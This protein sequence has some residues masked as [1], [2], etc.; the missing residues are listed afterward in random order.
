MEL[1]GETGIHRVF[2]H[3]APPVPVFLAWYQNL[4]SLYHNTLDLLAWTETSDGDC[5]SVYTDVMTAICLGYTATEHKWH[6]DVH[7]GFR[8]F[9]PA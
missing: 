7:E 8:T 4:Y 3:K 2:Q 1:A 9:T 5:G 6:G